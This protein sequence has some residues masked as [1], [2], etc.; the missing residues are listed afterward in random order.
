MD[1]IA[2]MASSVLCSS[3]AGGTGSTSDYIE[4]YE[5]STLGGY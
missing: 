5:S 3:P 1:V 2:M 4:D